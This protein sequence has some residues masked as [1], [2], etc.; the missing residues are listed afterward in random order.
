MGAGAI[1]LIGA[2]RETSSVKTPEVV[3]PSPDDLELVTAERLKQ[4]VKSAREAVS[5]APGSAATWGKLGH[6][7][8]VH[9]WHQPASQC[10]R[11]AGELEPNEF[12]WFY[13]LG[14]SLT[15]Q[16]RAEQAAALGRAVELDPTYAPAQAHYGFC[17]KDQGRPEEAAEHLERARDLDERN[18]MA[19]LG[20]GQLALAA[21]EY[22]E[23]VQ[24]LNRSLRLNPAQS[25]AHAGLVEAYRALDDEKAAARHMAAG[26]RRDQFTA[27]HDPLSEKI[28]EA[29][30]TPLWFAIRGAGFL[31]KGRYQQA[32]DELAIAVAEGRPDAEVRLNYGAALLQLGRHEEAVKVLR[33]AL[34][35]PENEGFTKRSP[36]TTYAIHQNLG[37]TH[38][39]AGNAKAA[40]ESFRAAL[41]IVPRSPGTAFHLATLY[42][43]QGRVSEAIRVLRNARTADATDRV[44]MLLADLLQQDGDHTGAR[45]VEREIRGRRRRGLPGGRR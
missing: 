39:A 4:A 1:A 10:Y 20:L 44:L 14:L 8:M 28:Q 41:A 31:M 5:K 36:Q 34:A 29:G 21:K 43:S 32:A 2:C 38:A 23:A 42:A 18:P 3:I 22:S 35:V 25:Q 7:Y 16:D 17:L 26:R 40:E 15:G 45:A 33:G 13:Y 19:E 24:H 9:G 30:A 11:R 27:M 6:V 37:M 12:R